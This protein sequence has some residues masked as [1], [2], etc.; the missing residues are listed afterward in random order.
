MAGT[1]GGAQRDGGEADAL[2]LLGEEDRLLQ[3]AF[4]EWDATR[5]N[6]YRHDTVAKFL[7]EHL[8]IREAARSAVVEALG[9]GPHEGALGA[10]ASSDRR[11][12]R[13]GLGALQEQLRGITAG[14][15]N[16]GQDFD[17][18]LAEVRALVEPE[19]AADLGGVLGELRRSG[20]GPG[21]ASAGWV[22]HHAPSEPI[23]EPRPWQ[24]V[25][26]LLR[27]RSFLDRVRRSPGAAPDFLPERLKEAERHLSA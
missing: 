4:E 16:I 26:P 20:I 1:E 6:R 3:T 11:P 2:E 15:L 23:V 22:R 5:P 24:R 14:E 21:L 17:G 19:L 9:P 27:L 18:K 13:A 10:F 25:G 8:A 7:L 12:M